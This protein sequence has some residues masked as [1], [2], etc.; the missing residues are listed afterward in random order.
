[1]RTTIVIAALGLAACTGVTRQQVAPVEAPSACDE[2]CAA[3]SRDW[4]AP[5]V[6]GQ[7]CVDAKVGP[8][9]VCLT[10]N[11]EAAEDPCD[12]LADPTM[13]PRDLCGRW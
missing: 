8:V 5:V 4:G 6:G 9:C 2:T 3:L 12:A 10:S 11:H 1:M 13:N 7:C